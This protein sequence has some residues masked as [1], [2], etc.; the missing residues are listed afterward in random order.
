MPATLLGLPSLCSAPRRLVKPAD[1]SAKG[2]TIAHCSLL[3]ARVI[4]FTITMVVRPTMC[5]LRKVLAKA[6]MISKQC[7]VEPNLRSNAPKCV[8]LA[9]A[10]C[11]LSFAAM[12]SL[13]SPLQSAFGCPDEFGQFFRS[14]GKQGFAAACCQHA[15]RTRSS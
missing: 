15:G 14:Q 4:G 11:R 5:H 2:S 6:T 10:R 7:T 3:L 9:K 1:S 12:P 13:R 8:E